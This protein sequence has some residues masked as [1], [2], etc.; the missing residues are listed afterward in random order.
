MMS[1]TANDKN[2]AAEAPQCES[3]ESDRNAEREV[4]TDAAKD[5]DAEVDTKDTD[6]KVGENASKDANKAD[7]DAD[8]EVDKAK[9]GAASDAAP[10]AAKSAP[11]QSDKPLKRAFM[12]LQSAFEQAADQALDAIQEGIERDQRA[13]TAFN[14]SLAESFGTGTEL[15]LFSEDTV[16]QVSAIVSAAA[17]NAGDA[18]APYLQAVSDALGNPDVEDLKDIVPLPLVT[19]YSVRTKGYAGDISPKRASRILRARNDAVL[20]DIRDLKKMQTEQGTVSVPDLRLGARGKGLLVAPLADETN[21]RVKPST[22]VFPREGSGRWDGEVMPGDVD[23]VDVG[24]GTEVL[25]RNVEMR[26]GGVEVTNVDVRGTKVT[27]ITV[28]NTGEVMDVVV[29]GDAGSVEAR[30][31]ESTD[32]VSDFFV[33]TRGVKVTSEDSKGKRMSVIDPDAAG[34][35]A[36]ELEP[37]GL[38]SQ[39]DMSPL[40]QQSE[41]IAGLNQVAEGKVIII[42]DE[43]G[44][45][46]VEMAKLLKSAGVDRP[47][48]VK[49]GYDAWQDKGLRT[50]EGDEYDSSPWQVLAEEYEALTEDTENVFEVVEELSR[51]DGGKATL[52]IGAGVTAWAVLFNVKLAFE[53]FVT[54]IILDQIGS[55]FDRKPKT[56]WQKINSLQQRFDKFRNASSQAN[57]LRKELAEVLKNVSDREK[58]SKEPGEDVVEEDHRDVVQVEESKQEEEEKQKEKIA[59]LKEEIAA[60]ADKEGSVLGDLQEFLSTTEG[61]SKAA[62]SVGLATLVVT[63][64]EQLFDAAVALLFVKVALDRVTSRAEKKSNPLV[65]QF[66]KMMRGEADK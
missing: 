64:S 7:A 37:S 58:M 10:E 35:G 14:E 51:S 25:E 46:S 34:Q 47:Y 16:K 45:D 48:V 41:I 31:V 12:N 55:S 49:G 30:A 19:A 21:E 15:V 20:V 39:K 61:K 66:D 57:Q 29:K 4:D 9:E 43:D 13:R 65:Q 6:G 1:A 5:Q 18:L 26:K 52:A 62:V 33:E 23:V 36:E 44:T 2:A 3:K 50:K 59:L 63:N 42:L 27:E 56:L 11:P 17:E 32:G 54:V 38:V 8:K 60:M 24:D 28:E 22:E 53:L 40:M